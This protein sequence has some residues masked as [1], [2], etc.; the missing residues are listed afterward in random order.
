MGTY[1][2]SLPLSTLLLLRKTTRTPIQYAFRGCAKQVG[3]FELRRL[4]P[5]CIS[6]EHF[7]RGEKGA[8]FHQ[9]M[10]RKHGTRPV[11]ISGVCC[12]TPPEY[13]HAPTTRRVVRLKR[14]TLLNAL[15]AL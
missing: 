6:L 3:S 5:D 14:R 4:T 9:N 11:V 12:K 13:W 7:L 8:D 1:R 10:M 2:I 15:I